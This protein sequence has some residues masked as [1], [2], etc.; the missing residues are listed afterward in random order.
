[1][2]GI[3]HVFCKPASRSPPSSRKLPL[4]GWAARR[5]RARFLAGRA[6]LEAGFG[7]FPGDRLASASRGFP[8][9]VGDSM[10]FL[11]AAELP[12]QLEHCDRGQ[13]AVAMQGHS[14]QERGGCLLLPPSVRRRRR[15][16]RCLLRQRLCACVRFPHLRGW[17]F[18]PRGRHAFR[19]GRPQSKNRSRLRASCSLAFLGGALLEAQCHAHLRQHPSVAEIAQVHEHIGQ[20]FGTAD[21]A[22]AALGLPANESTLAFYVWRRAGEG[23]WLRFS[24]ALFLAPDGPGPYHRPLMHLHH[25]PPPSTCR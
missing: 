21:E 25:S 12:G 19:G 14:G 2:S 20:H 5:G 15:R 6:F 4:V 9:P 18:G 1:M 24:L 23:T 16:G 11:S 3:D 7:V 22:E 17:F 8:T 10:Q 13:L